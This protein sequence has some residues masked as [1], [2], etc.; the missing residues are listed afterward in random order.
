MI[1]IL[2]HYEEQALSEFVVFI[3][4]EV[5]NTVQVIHKLNTIQK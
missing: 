5:I 3:D 1:L 4:S 2:I